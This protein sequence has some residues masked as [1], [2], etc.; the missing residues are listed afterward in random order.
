MQRTRE[1]YVRCQIMRSVFSGERIFNVSTADGGTYVGAAPVHYL[2]SFGGDEAGDS[3][4]APG[5]NTADG[6]IEALLIA[7]GGDEASVVFPGGEMA[8]VKKSQIRR[9]S[10][11]AME[12]VPV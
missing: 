12:N 7:N 4:P 8:R 6:W 2:F 11:K 9:G 10:P 5:E 3:I 1:I